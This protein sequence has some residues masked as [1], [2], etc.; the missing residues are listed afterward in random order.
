MSDSAEKDADVIEQIV[1]IEVV[2]ETELHRRD[3][4][5]ELLLM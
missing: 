1:L 5:C 2:K 3:G 4:R